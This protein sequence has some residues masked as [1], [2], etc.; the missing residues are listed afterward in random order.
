MPKTK[1]IE[2]NK[3][4]IEVEG[5]EFIPLTTMVSPD[6]SEKVFVDLRYVYE[7]WKARGWVDV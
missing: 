1:K 3:D 7:D 4:G 2:E 6:G 5:D